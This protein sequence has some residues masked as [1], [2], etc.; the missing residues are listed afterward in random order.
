MYLGTTFIPRLV[1]SANVKSM[2]TKAKAKIGMLFA[3]TPVNEVSLELAKG[4]FNCY[5]LPIFEFGM[6]IWTSDYCKSLDNS[7]DAVYLNFL[8]R[9]M[10]VHPKTRNSL[11]YHITN[12]SPLSNT[13]L[14]KNKK[15]EQNIVISEDINISELL[16][17]TD[18]SRTTPEKYVASENIPRTFYQNKPNYEKLPARKTYRTN[19]C[20]KL[21]DG[22]HRKICEN[23]TN[24][25]FRLD[26]K[27]T[28]I[29]KLC[30]GHADWNHQ[31]VR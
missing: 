30:G 27:Q 28:C 3:K 5:V 26:S 2:I 1:Y 18:R 29:C 4:L 21:V 11:I 17:L 16:L 20:I 12:T 13:M 6:I 7:I 15:Q 23:Y 22:H 8:K 14:E 9:Y 19:L 10:G 24:N 25:N 31:C